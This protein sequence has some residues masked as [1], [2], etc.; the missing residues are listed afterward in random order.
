MLFFGFADALTFTLDFPTL[1][2][3]AWVTGGEMISNL[4]KESFEAR[5]ERNESERSQ[6]GL[7]YIY[8]E[9]T[10]VILTIIYNFAL[11]FKISLTNLSASNALP[12]PA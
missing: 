8:F 4:G 11:S 7:H 5:V 12:Y 9:I 10:V 6:T 2:R 3:T 1:W